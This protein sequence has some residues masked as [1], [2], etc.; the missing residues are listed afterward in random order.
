M[1]TTAD[2]LYQAALQLPEGERAD[3]AAKL[4]DSIDPITDA[5]LD[6]A[7]D[8][9]IAKRIE[10]LEQGSVKAVPWAEA[11]RIIAGDKDEPHR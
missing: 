6:E 11:R 9:E 1:S 10:E 4:M 3:L 7:W 2:N 5:D 8:V